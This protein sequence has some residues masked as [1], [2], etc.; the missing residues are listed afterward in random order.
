M[1]Q[2]Y[3]GGD[4][5]TNVISNAQF[6]RVSYYDKY[7]KNFL[8]TNYEISNCQ[9]VQF[10]RM[11]IYKQKKWFYRKT[12]LYKDYNNTDIKPEMFYEICKKYLDIIWTDFYH[13]TYFCI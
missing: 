8:E 11:P 10:S 7:I 6:F 2:Y 9:K 5:I 1:E 3:I 13:E 4:T 12:Q